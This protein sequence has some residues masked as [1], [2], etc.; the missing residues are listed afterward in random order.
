VARPQLTQLSAN[1]IIFSLDKIKSSVIG[2]VIERSF[3]MEMQCKSL[4]R[5]FLR[6][7]ELLKNDGKTMAKLALINIIL[8]NTK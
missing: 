4:G 3:S 5:R 1:K 2:T 8:I 6:W 7:K